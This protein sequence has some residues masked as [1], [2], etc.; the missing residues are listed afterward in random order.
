MPYL[1]VLVLGG[2]RSGRNFSFAEIQVWEHIVRDD[3]YWPREHLLGRTSMAYA[4]G[5][6]S[7]E[8]FM[9]KN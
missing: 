5:L 7:D 6:E 9:V 3:T 2:K 1:H 4:A 8:H